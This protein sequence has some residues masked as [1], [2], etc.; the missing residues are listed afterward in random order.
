MKNEIKIPVSEGT[1]LIAARKK[2][3][4]T[5]ESGCIL[6]RTERKCFWQLSKKIR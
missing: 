5:L 3:M 1:E 4:I 2:G 6:S